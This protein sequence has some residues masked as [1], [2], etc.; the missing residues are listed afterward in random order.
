[1][2]FPVHSLTICK[3]TDNKIWTHALIVYPP[4]D[5]TENHNFFRKNIKKNFNSQ[6]TTVVT[7]ST[8][9]TSIVF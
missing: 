2:S 6:F 9:C 7:N 3:C 8:Y 1:M 4:A 5:S